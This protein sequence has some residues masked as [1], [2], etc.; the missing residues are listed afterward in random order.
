[1][2]PRIVER[3]GKCFST[4]RAATPQCAD[5]DIGQVSVRSRMTRASP[6]SSE[7]THPQNLCHLLLL[8][9]ATQLS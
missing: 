4:I 7:N 6:P 9:Q 2:Q 5:F 3:A 1:M 8:I